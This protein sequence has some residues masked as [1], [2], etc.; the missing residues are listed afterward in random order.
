MDFSAPYRADKVVVGS[1]EEGAGEFV[2]AHKDGGTVFGAPLVLEASRWRIQDRDPAHQG[3]EQSDV[4]A[5]EDFINGL[6]NQLSKRSKK[7]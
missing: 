5:L 1:V 3:F 6:I 7:R 4:A 2:V